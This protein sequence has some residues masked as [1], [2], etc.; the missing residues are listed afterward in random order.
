MSKKIFTEQEILE[1]SKN[2]YVKNVTAKGI[3]YTNEFKLQFI[4]EYENGKTSRAIFEDAGFD[5]NIIGIKRIDSASLRWRNAY[6]D[7]GILG[8][9]DTR[10]LNSGR[11]LN[12]ELTIEAVSY[13]HLTYSCTRCTNIS[14]IRYIYLCIFHSHIY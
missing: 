5:V 1:L 14:R 4:A 8:L 11:T 12:R 2:K 9:E 7:K 13:T 3:T 10:T 6:N